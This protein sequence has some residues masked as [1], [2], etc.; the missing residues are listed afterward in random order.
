[1]SVAP[2]SQ[3]SSQYLSSSHSSIN[4]SKKASSEISKT[5]KHVSQLYLTRRLA[6]AYEVL[7]PVI[8]PSVVSH[9]GHQS[10]DDG[11]SLAPI[12]IATTSQR[13]KIWSLFA[14]LM[15]AILDL[16][17]EQGKQEFGQK[18]YREI[19]R[20]VQNGDIWEQVVQDGY[21]GREASVDAEVVYNL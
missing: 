12:A 8:K 20:L 5:Y 9:D 13:I 2:E 6:E 18:Q 3:S 10:D 11:L 7:Q 1:M 16:G 14:A 4:Q 19:V 17:N 21:R 15:N